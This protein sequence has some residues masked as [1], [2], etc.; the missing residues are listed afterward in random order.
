MASCARQLTAF[1]L[2]LSFRSQVPLPLSQ[3]LAQGFGHLWQCFGKGHRMRQLLIGC[4]GRIG[5]A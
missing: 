3:P 4:F 5:I 2:S 1:C